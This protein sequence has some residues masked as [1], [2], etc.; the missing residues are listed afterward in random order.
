MHSREWVWFHANWIS[1]PSLAQG[2]DSEFIT[3][4]ERSGQSSG[5][6]SD[7]H[8]ADAYYRPMAEVVS[9]TTGTRG[10][11]LFSVRTSYGHRASLFCLTLGLLHLVIT[12]AGQFSTTVRPRKSGDIKGSEMPKIYSSPCNALP[13]RSANAKSRARMK[14]RGKS[15]RSI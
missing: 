15:Q 3:G 8:F 10:S 7:G 14:G 11:G 12:T 5:R 9:F 2:H 4:A 1:T 13:V 6:P